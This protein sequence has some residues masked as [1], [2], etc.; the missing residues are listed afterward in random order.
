MKTESQFLR[1]VV[2][3]ANNLSTQKFDTINKGGE[4]DLVTNLDLEIERFLIDEIKKNI[5]ILILLVKNLILII[6]SLKI[7]LL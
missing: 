3:K 1:D 6:K 5:Q 7:V 2:K 4:N